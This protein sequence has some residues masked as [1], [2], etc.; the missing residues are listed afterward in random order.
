MEWR[1]EHLPRDD[2]VVSR[3]EGAMHREESTAMLR[4]LA[5][6]GRAAGTS[7]LLVDARGGSLAMSTLEIY[8]WPEQWV[9]A[10]IGAGMRIALVFAEWTI[11]EIFLETQVDACPFA[12]QVFV[13]YDEARVWLFGTTSNAPPA[14]PRLGSE[15]DTGR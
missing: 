1:I 8:G 15:P 13:D 4:A 5:A 12:C 10:G 7:R 2:T 14:E 9:E 11:E 6:A 3:V